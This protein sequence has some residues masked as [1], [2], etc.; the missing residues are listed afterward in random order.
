MK[1]VP[2]EGRC[3][4]HKEDCVLLVV[5]VQTRLAPL[6]HEMDRVRG[7]IVKLIRFADIVGLPVVL[8]EQLNLGDTVPEI[9]D[10]LVDCDAVKKIEFD[11]FGSEAAAARLSATGRR[12]L[13]MAGIET[14]IC[15][16]Q[17]ALSG[18][19]G[20]D[21]HV[22]AD[23]TSSRNPVDRDIAFD[24]MRAAG[25]TLNSTE[26]LMYELL[27]RAGTDTFRKVLELVKT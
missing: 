3:L 17:T 15:V 5:D 27:K 7:N 21:V 1:D 13:L 6:I 16:A 24:R 8:T 18:L 2:V 25:V 19:R 4:L 26:M 12:A 23:A 11:C 9:R 20:F 10:A 22:I 14:H